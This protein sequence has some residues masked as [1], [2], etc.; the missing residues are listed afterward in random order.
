MI[1]NCFCNVVELVEWHHDFFPFFFFICVVEYG[2]YGER[3]EIQV[4]EVVVLLFSY[5]RNTILSSSRSVH[6]LSTLPFI[7]DVERQRAEGC[8]SVR[9]LFRSASFN[10][11]DRG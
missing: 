6:F 4:A 5:L 3:L 11:S 1:D 10:C 7:K 2:L 9:K 8:Y